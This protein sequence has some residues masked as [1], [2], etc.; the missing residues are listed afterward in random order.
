[1]RYRFVPYVLLLSI[2]GPVAAAAQ[3]APA[4]HI[5]TNTDPVAAAYDPVTHRAYVAGFEW[6]S[7]RTVLTEVDGTSRAVS[8]VTDIPLYVVDAAVN[9]VTHLVYLPGTDNNGLTNLA[10]VDAPTGAVAVFPLGTSPRFVDVNVATNRVYVEGLTVSG[11]PTLTVFDG[12]SNSIVAAL[13]TDTDPV[14]M[15]VDP[16]ANRVYVAGYQRIYGTRWLTIVDGETNTVLDHIETNTS[17]TAIA[18]DPATS[19]VYMVGY[20]GDS[21]APTLTVVDAAANLVVDRV[22]TEIQ[23]ADVAV[24][25]LH[26]RIFV[27]GVTNPDNTR[28][29][30]V[31]DGETRN[32]W[33]QMTVDTDPFLLLVDDAID[34][35]YLAGFRQPDN[36]RTLLI[37]EPQ[38]DQEIFP[39]SGFLAPVDATPVINRV[40][41]GAAVP[42]KFSL[43]RDR[44][45]A[46]FAAGY[47]GSQLTACGG[48]G[49]DDVE[50]A[51]AAGGSTLAYDVT[52]DQYTYVWKTNKAWAGTCRELLVRFV[53]GTIHVARFQFR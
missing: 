50:E 27:A 5:L 45:L 15:A 18:V 52:T 24:S 16:V 13:E 10:V 7:G 11:V 41:A 6:T 46:I 3:Y 19:R 28:I 8:A 20:D 1:M 14:A 23:A 17:S 2:C 35:I 40:R 38:K 30:A 43:G 25:P 29:L 21:G 31:F 33:Q 12:A 42:V 48:A 51:A 37:V 22:A 32:L 34:R 9:P 4:G 44:G 53:D 26:N 47:P 36:T 49:V 39:F